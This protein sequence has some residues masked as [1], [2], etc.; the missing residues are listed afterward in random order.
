MHLEEMK[1]FRFSDVYA[2][3]LRILP[4]KVL[5]CAGLLAFGSTLLAAEKPNVV[6]VITD[7]QGY[8]DLGCH[9]NTMIRTPHLD[10]L[11]GQSVRL[12][13]FHVSPC[14]TPT[15][16]SLMTGRDAIRTGAWGT[17]WG[18]SLPREDEVMMA[19]VFAASG[20]RTGFFGKWHLGD[21]YPF[22]PQDRGFQEVL[23][24]GGGGVGQLPDH[25]GNDYYSGVD[26]DGKPAK[27]DVYLENGKPVTAGRHC[28]DYWFERAKGFIRES[29]REN[30]PFFCYVPTNAAHGPFNAP[31]GHKK[32]FDGLI[33]NIDDNM[34]RLDA[35]LAEAELRDDVL[36]NFT[37]DNGTD[38]PVVSE[39]N[40]RR[41]AGGKGSMTDAGTRVPLIANGP[42]LI[43]KGKVC[44]DLV[45]FSD[46]LPTLCEAAG[47][48]VPATLNID[49]RSFLP[50]L[51]GQKGNPR[52]WIYC[53]YSRGG[54][55]T[56]EE[57]ARNQ[58]YKLYRTGKFYDV[59]K[60]VLEKKPLT[61]LSPQA[62]NIR[63]ML[64]QALDQYK[65]ARPADVTARG[66]KGKK[67]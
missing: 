65:D 48:T 14:C 37:T 38:K 16:A 50:Q 10:A 49:G 6:L 63:D 28:T 66:K 55:A 57:W 54:G 42:G 41:V 56:G 1:Y 27:A 17:T 3:L 64:Q 7:D 30:K 39:L 31:H 36:L 4:P 26:W 40:G 33:G 62:R 44:S 47:A 5:A 25:W 18:R 23:A 21:N 61:D 34:G 58:R 67:K 22:R 52:D 51:K 11:Y 45:D 46:F 53:W 8:G 59:S 60:D 32:G 13:D 35:F 12:T 24:H 20:Y 9:G 29:V 19:Q 2:S 43:P 15:R